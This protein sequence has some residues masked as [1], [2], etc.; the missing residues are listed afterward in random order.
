MTIT[1]PPVALTGD[2]LMLGT[3]AYPLYL[4][5][6]QNEALLFE[7]GVG[8]CGPVLE[9]QLAQLGIARDT[10]KQVVVTHGHPDHV[11]AVPAFRRMFPGVKVLASAIAAVTMGNEKA[12]GFFCKVDQALTGSLLQS[13][14][15][16]DK[17]RPQA[18]SE[19]KIPV[20]SVLKEG[21]TVMVG[22]AKFDVLATPG[23]SDC[24]LSFLDPAGKTLVCSD[25]T[26]YY[27]PQHQAWWP[28]YFSDYGAYVNSIRRLAALGAEV[29]CLSH[30]AAIVGAADVK[31]YF[32]GAI[33]ATEAYHHRIVEAVK[34]GRNAQEL[35]GQLAAEIHA[36]AGLMPLDF[37]QKNCGLLIKLSLKHEGMQT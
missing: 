12:V 30:N 32:D 22:R 20:D 6:L 31:A 9:E 4:V 36:K 24:S 7:G 37:F 33:A 28:N 10:V 1:K 11:M 35:A 18:L 14:A 34:A 26:G 27:M 16:T 8:A 29:L 23:H 13:G 15:I 21:D 17:H 5:K 3:S 2:M 19:L 25:A